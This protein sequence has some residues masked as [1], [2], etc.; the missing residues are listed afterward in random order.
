MF[1]CSAHQAGV[2]DAAPAAAEAA[3]NGAAKSEG[4]DATGQDGSKPDKA[5]EVQLPAHL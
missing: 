5:D 3:Q 4:A 2:D 1:L